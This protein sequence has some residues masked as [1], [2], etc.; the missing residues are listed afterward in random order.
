MWHKNAWF[1][2]FNRTNANTAYA[3]KGLFTGTAKLM[4]KILILPSKG[5]AAVTQHSA[6]YFGVCTSE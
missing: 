4:T 5:N 1:I 2:S 3:T 6:I